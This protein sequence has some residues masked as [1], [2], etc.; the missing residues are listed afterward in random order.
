MGFSNMVKGDW[1]FKIGC[2]TDLTV[3]ICSGTEVHTNLS[4]RRQINDEHG[5]HRSIIVR[6]S[7]MDFMV[8]GNKLK[9]GLTWR[10]CLESH[11]ELG[12][13]RPQWSFCS[14]G[15]EGALLTDGRG[16]CA[17]ILH[18]SVQG[19]ATPLSGNDD[20]L[21]AG[22][23]TTMGTIR[24][25]IASKMEVEVGDVGHKNGVFGD[26]QNCQNCQNC[27]DLS[28]TT[29]CLDN[30]IQ[31]RQSNPY[32]FFSPNRP[33]SLPWTQIDPEIKEVFRFDAF[34]L[35]HRICSYCGF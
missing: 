28:I 34:L 3:G 35:Q 9:Q 16:C 22:L 24:K 10:D 5:W 14:P 31:L 12:G 7:A 4:Y 15:D 33:A 23:V 11:P 2:T 27:I 26:D 29:V 19:Y 17:G 13:V 1:Y 18:G 30:L 25:S 8:V 6:N 20:Y 21:R 32:C